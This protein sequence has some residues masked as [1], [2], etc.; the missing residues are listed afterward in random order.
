ML[1]VQDGKEAVMD[2]KLRALV[3]GLPG[4]GKTYFAS[5]C[6]KVYYMGFSLGEGDTF[7][8]Q[9]HLSKNMVKVCELV[10]GDDDELK[11]L[12]GD[13][14]NGLDNGLVHKL[15]NEAK[16][17]FKEG[18][19]DT[20][21]IDTLTY[22]VD[23]LWLYMNKFCVKKTRDGAIDTRGMYGDLN[24]KLSRLV[25][26]LIMS[27]PGNLICTTHEMLENDEAMDKKIDKTSPV[28]ANILGGFRNKVEGM[29]SLNMYLTKLEDK[30]KYQ[31][32][33][34]VNKG[35][36]RNGKSRIPLPSTVQG[37]SYQKIMEVINKSITVGGGDKDGQ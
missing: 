27:F 1:K 14:D 2:I 34:R 35:N 7:K 10:P 26:L 16:T 19:V 13:L 32:W 25:G 15:V 31:Y 18:K 17:L 12:F 11:Q 23:Y 21:V 37:I 30:G 8:V 28:V 33:A 36:Q 24:T 29:F 20:L 9:P 6:P 4:S 3:C 22:L 5:T